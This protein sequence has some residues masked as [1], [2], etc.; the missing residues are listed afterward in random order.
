MIT[1]TKP[2]VAV[3]TL[4]INDNIKYLENIKK[5]FKRIISWNKHWSEILTQSKSNNLDYLLDPAFSNI[6]SLFSL[7]FRNGENDPTRISF[8]K[9]Y[10]PLVE[11]DD[12]DALVGN[13]PFLI[14]Q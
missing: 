4:P 1:I 13:K 3:V 6:H 12:F 10:M 7:S 11:I 5:G 2:Y 9:Y 8:D 14:S